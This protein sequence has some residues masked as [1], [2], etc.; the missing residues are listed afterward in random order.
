MDDLNLSRIG[1]RLFAVAEANALVP[2]LKRTFARIRAAR[3][4]MRAELEELQ[5][6][7][8]RPDPVDLTPPDDVDAAVVARFDRLRD[9][10]DDVLDRMRELTEMG[11][12][13]KGAD[14]L[15]DVR[16]SYRGRVVYLCWQ[17]GEDAFNFWHETHAGFA[18]RQVVSD[19]SEF[20]GSEVN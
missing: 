7:G 9:L 14:G 5:A 18:G 20:L 4:E 19:A 17:W 11:I 12:D 13:V 10:R 3:A 8:L 15:V 16:A 1:E 6:Q 2:T